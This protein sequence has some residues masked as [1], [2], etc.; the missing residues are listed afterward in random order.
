MPALARGQTPGRFAGRVGRGVNVA[1]PGSAGAGERQ[2]TR[3]LS[4]QH[5]IF[6]RA[7]SHDFTQSPHRRRRSAGT[8]VLEG[9]LRAG[10]LHRHRSG[11]RRRGADAGQ[12][13]RRSRAPRRATP[14][15]RR[16]VH[17]PPHQGAVAGDAG[18]PDDR[19]LQRRERR[20]SDEARRL[21]LLQQAVQP[22]R[23]RG[24]RRQG[25]GDQPPAPRGA[26][27]AL[28]PGARVPASTPSSAAPRRC[29]PS[30]RCSPAWPTVPRP[31]CC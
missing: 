26:D 17:P 28:E 27:A 7:Q 30:S 18:H 2:K 15:W 1:Q 8:V 11:H 5:G 13:W 10:R 19:L 20:R 16:P 29:S 6:P 12:P 14:G 21:Q 22:R 9:A 23:R 24:D 3:E 31:R 25:A 4:Q